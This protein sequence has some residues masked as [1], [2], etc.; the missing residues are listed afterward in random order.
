[1][2]NLDYA[3]MLVQTSVV[4]N[5][6]D[7]KTARLKSFRRPY[8]ILIR[9]SSIFLQMTERLGLPMHSQSLGSGTL[10]HLHDWLRDISTH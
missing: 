4:L 1:M 7:T 9:H 6:K 3:R 5:S 8:Q 2:I 10:L